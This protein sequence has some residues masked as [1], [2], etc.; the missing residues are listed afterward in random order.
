MLFRSDTDW[1]KTYSENGFVSLNISES[2]SKAPIWRLLWK[3][4]KKEKKR[5]F[6]CSATVEFT[7][8][9]WSYAQN[10]DQGST[11]DDPDVLFLSFSA[12]FAIPSRVL[13]FDEGELVV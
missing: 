8:D 11:L 3:K 6:Y 7:Y 10:F 4:I 9:P 2:G 13:V 12:R 5:I 1:G